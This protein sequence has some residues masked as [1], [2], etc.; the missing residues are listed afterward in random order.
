LIVAAAA[1]VRFAILFH[2]QTHVH[3]DEAIIGLMGK[4]IL[5]GKFFPFYMYGQD[6]NA[7]AAWEAYLAV[8]PYALFGV[9]VVSLKSGIVLL[10]LATLV[11]MTELVYGRSPAIAATV[12]FAL[13]PSLLKWHF[14]VRGYSWYFLSIPILTAL[15]AAIATS[16]RPKRRLVFLF[17]LATG[18]SVW[19]LE[20]VLAVCVALWALLAVQRRLSQKATV[21][22][23]AGFILGYAPAIAFNVTHHFVNWTEVFVNKSGGAGLLNPSTYVAVFVRELPKFFG[24]DTT[25][26]YY[27]ETPA[28]GYAFYAIALAAVS[29]ALAPFVKRP[30]RVYD[31]LRGTSA[32]TDESKDLV[33]LVLTAA[34][35]VPYLVAPVR[36]PGYFLGGCVFISVLTG[37]LL[38]RCWSSPKLPVRVA[39]YALL[40][41]AAW[42]G[43]AA[44]VETGRRNQI[45]TLSLNAAGAFDLTRY[46]GADI[47]AVERHLRDHQI[48]SVW[49]TV[50]FVYPLVF[51]S[52]EALAV[53]DKAFGGGQDVYP[54]AV[55]RRQPGGGPRQVFVLESASPLRAAVVGRSTELFGA[56]PAV[57]EYGSLV[58]IEVQRPR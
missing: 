17:G 2:S 31:G 53:S 26:W 11:A 12:L 51:E 36:V 24:P 15:Y 47:D 44:L 9:G 16:T 39:G 55:A 38:V 6:Y 46:P 18:L 50:S 3:S 20:L 32:M 10:S 4:H 35:F 27:P 5:E 19:S 8:I 29:V 1:V 41:V 48:D 30:A 21:A 52:G 22:A 49:A 58:V 37:R 57:T 40:V 56:P 34:S 7:G 45:E 28:I 13:S 14:Q 43:I 54:A 33:M 42:G 25:L 23:V